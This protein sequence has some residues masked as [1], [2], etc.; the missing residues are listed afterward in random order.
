MNRGD[1]KAL[2]I[3]QSTPPREKELKTMKDGDVEYTDSIYI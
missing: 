3:T 2:E 1:D